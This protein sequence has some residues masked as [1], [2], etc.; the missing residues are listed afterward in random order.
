M[1]VESIGQTYQGDTGEGYAAWQNTWHRGLGP[2]VARKFKSEIDC[3]HQV[4]DFGCGDGE[5]LLS[6]VCAKRIGIEPNPSAARAARSRGLE[7]QATLGEIP[8]RS[9]DAVMSHHAL[10]HCIRPIDELV[11]MR[12]V[13]KPGGKLILVVPIDDWRSQ[14]R[15]DPSDI[16]HHLCTWTPQL[17]GNSLTEAGFRVDSIAVSHYIWPPKA[18]WSAKNLP[19]IVFDFLAGIWSRVINIREIRAIATSP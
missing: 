19:P 14:R 11:S 18:H 13:L 7:V 5:N 9:V 3:S 8:D 16:H 15:F 2:T 10:E 17:L 1:A 6:V 12:R 4:L